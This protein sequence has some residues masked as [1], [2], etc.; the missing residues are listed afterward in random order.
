MRRAAAL[1]RR[2]PACFSVPLGPVP[3]VMGQFSPTCKTNQNRRT[4]RT[5]RVIC[6]TYGDI[7][8]LGG[9]LRQKQNGSARSKNANPK[10]YSLDDE[11][12]YGQ[13]ANMWPRPSLMHYSAS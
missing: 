1:Y 11:L 9:V 10:V 7:H 2:Q 13:L 4:H 3:A 8:V 6:P 12:P 5:R